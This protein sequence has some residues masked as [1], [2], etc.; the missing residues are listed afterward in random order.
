MK[1]LIVLVFA[2]LAVVQAFPASE[3]V[4]NEEVASSFETDVGGIENE[5]TDELVR[6]KRQYG[7]Y[8]G[9]GFGGE[10]K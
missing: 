2:A 1:V 9:G 5:V 10:L 7:G 8:G 4:G 6:D 3:S